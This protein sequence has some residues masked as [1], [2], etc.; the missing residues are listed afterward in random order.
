MREALKAA[1]VSTVPYVIDVPITIAA[2]FMHSTNSLTFEPREKP[3]G[4]KAE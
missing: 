1:A 4:A 3:F 2:T